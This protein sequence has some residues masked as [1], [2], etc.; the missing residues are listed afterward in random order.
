MPCPPDTLTLLG[1]DL[2]AALGYLKKN[3][4]LHLLVPKKL[5]AATRPLSDLQRVNLAAFGC[6]LLLKERHHDDDD[7]DESDFI[8]A[9]KRNL[10]MLTRR[11]T[12]DQKISEEESDFL[13][14]IRQ[15]DL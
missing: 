12:Y 1:S 8:K 4:L 11:L 14:T 13:A 2:K 6:L 7:N 3:S 10:E 9:Q 15:S 5:L